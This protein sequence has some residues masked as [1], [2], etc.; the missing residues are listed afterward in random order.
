MVLR[1]FYYIFIRFLLLLS[2][3][4]AATPDSRQDY[5]ELIASQAHQFI[6]TELSR[7]SPADQ[8]KVTLSSIDPRLKLDPC[9]NDLTYQLHGSASNASNVTIKISCN[10]SHNWSFYTNARV[11]R[12]RSVAVAREN[13]ARGVIIDEDKVKADTRL[14]PSAGSATYSSVE[15]AMGM[16]VRRAVRKGDIIR[17]SSLT[18]PLAVEKGDQVK[19][20]AQQDGLSIVTSGIALTKGKIG[21]QIRVRNLRS[22]RVIKA[23]ISDKG[24]VDVLL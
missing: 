8:I 15:A 14:I 1:S 16:E 23:R 2:L 19:I 24:L 4:A 18:Q 7:R 12:Y 17:T 3:P 6:L 11:D 20:R 21:E 10:S 5:L 13:L 9:D 22:E